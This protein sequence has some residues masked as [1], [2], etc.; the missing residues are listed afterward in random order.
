[1]SKDLH[2]SRRVSLFPR[3]SSKFVIAFCFLPKRDF[4]VG[5]PCTMTSGDTVGVGNA[6]VF[7]GR[8]SGTFGWLELVSPPLLSRASSKVV[9]GGSGELVSPPLLVLFS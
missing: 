6:D 2:D 1:M 5:S 7:N 8:F 4:S 3:N 9:G